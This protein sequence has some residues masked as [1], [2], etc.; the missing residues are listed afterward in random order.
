MNEKEAE[1]ETGYIYPVVS[2]Q[3]YLVCLWG[4][5][6]PQRQTDAQPQV[7]NTCSIDQLTIVAQSFRLKTQPISVLYINDSDERIHVYVEG[8]G[9]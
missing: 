3:P 4:F 7:L 5:P 2:T 8:P 1:V 9:R 6:N